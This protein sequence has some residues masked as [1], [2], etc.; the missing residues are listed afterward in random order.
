MAEKKPYIVSICIDEDCK[1]KRVKLENPDNM[2]LTGV[3]GV[4][5]EINGELRLVLP[6]ATIDFSDFKNL[7]DKYEIPI[8]N[9]TGY[10]TEIKEEKK[11]ERVIRFESK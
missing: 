6:L 11:G 1:K 3:L 2:R 10:A 4:G 8:E 7:S 5:V 9:I